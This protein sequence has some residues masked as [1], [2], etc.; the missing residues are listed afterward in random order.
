M[1]VIDIE[2]GDLKSYQLAQDNDR[3][4][5]LKLQPLVV[6]E[7]GVVITS[8]GYRVFAFELF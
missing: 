5:N 7:D 4:S 8:D 3:S 1:N 2:T 6:T